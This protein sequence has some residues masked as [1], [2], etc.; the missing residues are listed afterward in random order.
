MF[1]W[2]KRK[3][4]AR[5]AG[6][7]GLLKAILEWLVQPGNRRII[8]AV[9]IGVATT[10][11]NLGHVVPAEWVDQIK[12]IIETLVPGM[13]AGAMVLLAWSIFTAKKKAKE[14]VQ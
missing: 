11:R 9:L 1:G 13:D 14:G 2:L 4:V 7:S 12:G 10:L 3:L 8:V 5:E 6:K